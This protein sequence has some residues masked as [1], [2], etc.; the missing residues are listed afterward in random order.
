MDQICPRCN[1]N[2]VVKEKSRSAAAAAGLVG[3]MI[4]SAVKAYKCPSCGKIRL[5]EF[6][7]EFQARV[8]RKRIF[9]A[10]G[11]VGVLIVLFVLLIYVQSM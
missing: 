7:D 3:S 9:S 8:K 6:P 11:A 10:L 5:S 2:T 1:E 4:A